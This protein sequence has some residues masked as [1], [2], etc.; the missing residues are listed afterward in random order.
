MPL[1][2]L[3]QPPDLSSYTPLETHQS[4]TPASFQTPVL[5]FHAPSTTLL[6]APEH[7]SLLPIFPD[8]PTPSSSSPSSSAT[9]PDQLQIPKIELL[10]SSQTLILY[11][12]PSKIGVSLPYPSVT[13][14]AIQRTPHGV[15]IYVQIS[16]SPANA[17]AHTNTDEYDQDELLEITILPD[18]VSEEVVDEMFSALSVCAGLNPDEVGSGDDEEGDGDG[19]LWEGDVEAGGEGVRF[20]GFPTGAG[21]ITAENVG[22]FRFD[23]PAEGD[24]QGDG[25]IVLGP[26]AGT[27]RPRDE[28]ERGEEEGEKEGA[29]GEGT[30]EAKWRRTG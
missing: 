30:E 4:S 7:I 26:G 28:V 20:E 12:A 9:A 2:I 15:G 18:P 13:L 29:I 6:I 24:A 25:G 3:R 23:D 16:L 10:I 1:T 5:H 22:D 14:H 17:T 21:W 27:V 11:N 8:A 19:I